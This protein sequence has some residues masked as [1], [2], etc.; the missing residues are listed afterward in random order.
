MRRVAHEMRPVL[1]F[2]VAGLG[3]ADVG[4]VHERGGVE[5]RHTRGG[6][7]TRAGQRLQIVV[8]RRKQLFERAAIARLRALDERPKIGVSS[9]TAQR[10]AVTSN[11]ANVPRGAASR[12]LC[13]PRSRPDPYEPDLGRIRCPLRPELPLGPKR[14]LFFLLQR[15]QDGDVERTLTCL[16]FSAA[17]RSQLAGER[18]DAESRHGVGDIIR[19]I[20]EAARGLDRK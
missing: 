15:A 17:D 19:H 18:I 3:Q 13:W 9:H 20:G 11:K 10:T 1:R 8:G 14:G 5:H 12:R 16:G 7:Q 4:F 2:Q 6:A